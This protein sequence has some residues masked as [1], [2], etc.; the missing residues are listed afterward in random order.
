MNND[1]EHPKVLRLYLLGALDDEIVKTR[2]E[3]HLIAN[4]DTAALLSTAEEAL[5]EEFLDGEMDSDDTA[6]FNEFFLAPPER[7]R[8]L[9]LTQDLRTYASR[10]ATRPETGRSL[11]EAFHPLTNFRWLR[12]AVVGA[13]VIAVGL[14]FWRFAYYEDDTARGIAQLQAMYRDDRPFRSRV[15]LIPDYAPFSET[16]GAE[17]TPDPTLRDRAQRYLFDA[18]ANNTESRAHHA[19][20]MYYLTAREY[21][22]ARAELDLAVKSA[23][24]DAKLQ[25]DAGAAFLE[26]LPRPHGSPHVC[27]HLR[28]LRR[29]LP[30]R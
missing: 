20:A 11:S 24:N 27:Q 12:F 9:R 13:V 8:Q 28:R 19:L 21:D 30:S 15:T 29:F 26:E 18:T 4:D 16:R 7:R 2:I 5:I 14:A 3:E 6:K 23:P 1:F 22:K 25:S 17:K 10:S